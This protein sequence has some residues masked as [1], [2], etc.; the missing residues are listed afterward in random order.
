MF[1]WYRKIHFNIKVF[2]LFIHR[3]K[4]LFLFILLQFFE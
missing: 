4:E 3:L 1:L 2:H